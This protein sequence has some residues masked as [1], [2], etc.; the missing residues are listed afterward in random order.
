LLNW[1]NMRGIQPFS[2]LPG[3]IFGPIY[4]IIYFFRLQTHPYLL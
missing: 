3:L 2:L 1:E 4:M